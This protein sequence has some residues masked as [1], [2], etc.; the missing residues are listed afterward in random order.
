M[1]VGGT[2][3]AT[4]ARFVRVGV[5][6]RKEDSWQEGMMLGGRALVSIV[7]GDA[8]RVVLQSDAVRRGGSY[9]SHTSHMH[10][11]YATGLAVALLLASLGEMMPA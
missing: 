5:T 6:G 8:E 2:G 1:R 3:L 10:C 11:R 4:P 7:G 9:E